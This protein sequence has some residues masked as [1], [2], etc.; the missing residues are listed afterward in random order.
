MIFVQCS[1][2]PPKSSFFT[3]L[4]R[5]RSAFF[6]SPLFFF[7]IDIMHGCDTS[8]INRINCSRNVWNFWLFR[9]Y[10]HVGSRSTIFTLLEFLKLFLESLQINTPMIAL[11][12]T[13][14]TFAVG[15]ES[16]WPWIFATTTNRQGHESVKNISAR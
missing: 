14:E 8:T 4:V 10:S 16:P 13:C 1:E 15:R 12:A 2:P 3:L 9:H 7:L 6:F 5:F 11:Y